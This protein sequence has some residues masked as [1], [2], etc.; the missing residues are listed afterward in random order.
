MISTAGSVSADCTYYLPGQDVLN[1]EGGTF[2]PEEDISEIDLM[3]F[4][5]E[6]CFEE[7]EKRVDRSWGTRVFWLGI[8]IVAGVFATK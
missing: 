5:G 8:G 6:E 3:L 4:E 1:E 2:C 7:L